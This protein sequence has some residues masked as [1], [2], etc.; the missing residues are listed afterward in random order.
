MS[1]K[2]PLP[3]RRFL[4][5]VLITS[6]LFSFAGTAATPLETF[7]V[8]RIRGRRVHLREGIPPQLTHENVIRHLGNGHLLLADRV[9]YGIA[10]DGKGTGT[11]LHVVDPGNGECGWVNQ[12]FVDLLS[13]EAFE[14]K[15]VATTDAS[16]SEPHTDRSTP[17]TAPGEVTT[18]SNHDTAP[19]DALSEQPTFL[20][21]LRKKFGN[22]IQLV[23]GL[24]NII[25]MVLVMVQMMMLSPLRSM[26]AL[27]HTLQNTTFNISA[28]TAGSDTASSS[29]NFAYGIVNGIPYRIPLNKKS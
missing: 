20:T 15:A 3:N 1:M 17:V 11:W 22:D 12:R 28:A 5:A 13:D 9:G 23:A 10:Y 8:V 4:A 19:A 27:P 16:G 2:R 29:P 6:L 18:R 7:R 21:P 24:A 26:T 25:A 14:P